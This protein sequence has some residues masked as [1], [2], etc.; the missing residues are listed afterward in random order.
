MSC[1]ARMERSFVREVSL[2]ALLAAQNRDG[3]WGF[4]AGAS[5]A[6][7]PT[8]WGLLAISGSDYDDSG[9]QRKCRAARFLKGAQLPEGSWPAVIGQEEGGWVTSIACL[10]LRAS[11]G[12]S[13]ETSRGL[14]WL[15]RDWPG[16]GGLWWRM[17]R[18]LSGETRLAQANYRL[19]GWSWTRGTSSWVEP[20]SHALLALR[21]A[22]LSPDGS[23]RAK[24]RREL[25][26]KMLCSRM[27][28][29]GGWNCGNAWVYGAPGKPLIGPTAWALVAL[30]EFAA[31]PGVQD[32]V[33]EG[34]DWLERAS[35]GIRGPGS[36]AL[37]HLCLRAYGR[38]G[39]ALDSQF[40]AS[41]QEGGFMQQIPVLAWATL[42]LRSSSDGSSSAIFE[43]H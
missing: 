28:P 22:H 21:G 9:T 41:Y 43:S 6:V 17:R 8:S 12:A 13:P 10:A 38:A 27:C 36:L 29:G 25:G 37:A 20:T 5:S 40:F 32:C 39:G 42:A 1:V 11:E 15:C 26:Q 4:S 34:L 2:P 33:R 16:E 19:R 23:R 18:R 31:E 3:G 7:E 24:H 30:A 35:G 14:D